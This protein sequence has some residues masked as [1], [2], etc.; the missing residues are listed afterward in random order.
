MIDAGGGGIVPSE[1]MRG[2]LSGAAA[3]RLAM[4]RAL[5]A[6]LLVVDVVH[7]FADLSC[8]CC[9]AFAAVKMLFLIWHR[10]LRL[11]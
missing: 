7:S 1:G 9:L 5:P 10:Q 11:D 8:A 2:S 6:A 3:L 4:R